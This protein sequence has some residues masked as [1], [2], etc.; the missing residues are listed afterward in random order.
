MWETTAGGKVG[1]MVITRSLLLTETSVEFISASS[2]YTLGCAKTVQV[3]KN[4]RA[5]LS[6]CSYLESQVAENSSQPNPLI[7]GYSKGMEQESLLALCCQRDLFGFCATAGSQCCSFQPPT[8]WPSGVAGQP[9][10]M[11]LHHKTWLHMYS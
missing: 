8:V 5:A 10:A 3:M 1:R 6:Y 4:L 9:Q 7:L 2:A 11:A